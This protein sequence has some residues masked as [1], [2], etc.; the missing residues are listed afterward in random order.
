MFMGTHVLLYSTNPDADRRFFADILGF[1][2]VVV[3]GGWLIFKLPP[4][5]AA[6]HPA[7]APK[8]P[9]HA[10]HQL[11]GAVLYLMCDD[12]QKTVSTLQSRG[13]RCTEIEREN[14]GIRTTIPLPSGAELGLYQPTH[15][16][17][18]ELA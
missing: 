15:P 7:D 9:V 1:K 3:G 11:A 2:S 4:A 16:T 5:E 12:L 13:V 14:W 18:L 17:A 6:V 10:G 8:N